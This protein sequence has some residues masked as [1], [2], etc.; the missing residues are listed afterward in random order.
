[1]LHKTHYS[2]RLRNVLGLLVLSVLL[3]KPC[4]KAAACCTDKVIVMAQEINEAVLNRVIK[5]LYLYESNNGALRNKKDED[6]NTVGDYHV[7]KEVRDTYKIADSLPEIDQAK[8]VIKAMR[9]E[10]IKGG[11]YPDGKKGSTKQIQIAGF[12]FDSLSF[13]E[14]VA[15]LTYVY[16]AGLN[17]PNFRGSL[18][19]LAQARATSNVNSAHIQKLARTAAGFIDV[20]GSK[21]L[22]DYAL[23]KRR[24]AEKG[25]F[26][27]GLE[28]VHPENLDFTA[29]EAADAIKSDLLFSQDY[30]ADLKKFNELKSAAQK[31]SQK[32][33]L[34]DVDEMTGEVTMSAPTPPAPRP[35]RSMQ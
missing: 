12:D 6:G 1:M 35:Q 23:A 25:T 7:T 33:G 5:D 11:V 14:Q 10:L 28:A 15:T 29:I 3:V 22:G 32:F 27:S 4:W 19:H 13:D 16:N 34:V 17:Q 9:N 30:Y 21:K 26:L 18:G 2:R 31:L 8:A 20:M 24:M